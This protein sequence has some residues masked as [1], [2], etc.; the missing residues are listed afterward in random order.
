MAFFH[1]RHVCAEDGVVDVA[2]AQ[3]LQGRDHLA[4]DVGAGFQAEGFAEARS[5]GGRFLHHDH[6]V[7]GQGLFDLVDHTFV[8][9]PAERARNQAL[10]AA[11]AFRGVDDVFRAE[12]VHG[13]GVVRAHFDAVV[14]SFAIISESK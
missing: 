2:E 5:D 6:L 10:P 12:A 13:D 1:D 7:A 9:D 8:F 11:Q 14:A 4:F 3:L